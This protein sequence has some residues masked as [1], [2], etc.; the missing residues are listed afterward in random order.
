MLGTFHALKQNHTWATSQVVN[1]A[2]VSRNASTVR[3]RE[4]CAIFDVLS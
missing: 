4:T 3:W 1:I 2:Y